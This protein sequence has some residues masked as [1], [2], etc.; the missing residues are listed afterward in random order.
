MASF[1]TR[2]TISQTSS[3]QVTVG[4]AVVRVAVSVAPEQIAGHPVWTRKR[5]DLSRAVLADPQGVALRFALILASQDVAV[6]EPDAS[7]ENKVRDIWDAVAGVT[8]E[9]RKA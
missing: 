3:F 1:A 8:A 5:G 4:I 9:D 6:D 2:Y 7:V